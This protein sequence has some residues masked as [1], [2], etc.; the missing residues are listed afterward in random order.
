MEKI[1]NANW[2]SCIFPASWF[3]EYHMN[4]NVTWLEQL[5]K[6]SE[7]FTS[8]HKVLDFNSYHPARLE[9]YIATPFSCG[10]QLKFTTAWSLKVVKVYDGHLYRLIIQVRSSI[11]VCLLA[12]MW[13]NVNVYVCLISAWEIFQ[14]TKRPKF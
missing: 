9:L 5:Q 3:H 12:D 4:M 10:V 13:N 11:L 2:S 1:L 14:K 6:P 8:T 7:V